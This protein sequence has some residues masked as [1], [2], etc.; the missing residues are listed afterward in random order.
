MLRVLAPQRQ[1]ERSPAARRST[2]S[3]VNSSVHMTASYPPPRSSGRKD[4]IP[5]LR[6]PMA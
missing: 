3:I 1:V 4:H 2:P 5:A 6:P